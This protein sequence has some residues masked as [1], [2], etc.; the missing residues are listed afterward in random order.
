M[1]SLRKPLLGILFVATAAVLAAC[2]TSSAGAPPAQPAQPVADATLTSL[3]LTSGTARQNNAQANTGD[4]FKGSRTDPAARKWVQ[5]SAGTAGG[6]S[7]IV[8]DAAGFTLY[9]FDKDSASPPTS[10]CAGTCA[11]TWPPVLVEPGS[12]VFLDGVNRAN[13]G[14]VKRADGTRQLT[15]GGWPIYRYSKDT[16]AG[17]VNGEGV[18]GTW[19]AVSP[20][21]AKVTAKATGTAAPAPST[22]TSAP[23]LGNGS[24]LLDSGK[25]FTEP[26]GSEGIAGPGCKNVAHPGLA[27]SLRLTGGPVKVWSGAGCTG[28]S[29]LVTDDVADLATIGMDKKITSIKFGG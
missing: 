1:K 8:H 14:V 2:G 24:V 22:S 29:A 4:F 23:A 12:K 3:Q 9:R 21:G 13:V 17:Q 10:N 6:L 19:F 11:T 15:L 7:P 27:S 26:D 28:T 5:L 20:T 25:N 18:S 16:A